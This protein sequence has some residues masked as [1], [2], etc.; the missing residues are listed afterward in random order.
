MAGLRDRL[1]HGYFGVDHDLVWDV[2]TNKVPDLQ[3]EI[4]QLL[5]QDLT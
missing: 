4:A 1:V 3:R 2:I 5:T